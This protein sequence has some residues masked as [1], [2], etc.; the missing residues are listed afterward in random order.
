LSLAQDYQKNVENANATTKNKKQTYQP[1]SKKPQPNIYTPIKN[2]SKSPI[3]NYLLMAKAIIKGTN[4]CP[5]LVA[6][7]SPQSSQINVF[8]Y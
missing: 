4:C 2:N 3:N 7:D 1:H 5:L 8:C 6:K